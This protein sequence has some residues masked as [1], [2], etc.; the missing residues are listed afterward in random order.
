MA[1]YTNN[2]QLHQWEPGDN[3]LREDF[4]HDFAKIDTALGGKSEIVCGSYVGDGTEDRLIS[5]GFT[6]KAVLVMGEDGATRMTYQLYG[7]L[8]LS[9]APAFLNLGSDGKFTVLAVAEGGFLVT[10][11]TAS[12]AYAI[13]TNTNRHEYRYLAL[14]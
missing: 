3:F 4:N 11:K 7:G 8:A 1:G 2:Y 10:Q 6:P 5:L 14:K 13:C 12:A 9:G